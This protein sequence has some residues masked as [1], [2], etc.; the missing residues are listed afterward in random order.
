[1]FQSVHWKNMDRGTESVDEA[2]EN[3]LP[4]I[5]PET[6]NKMREL[7]LDHEGQMPPLTEMTPIISAIITPPKKIT[8][9]QLLQ[10]QR[11][12]T[13]IQTIA[14]VVIIVSFLIVNK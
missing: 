9:N 1:M 13:K 10:K 8:A 4:G 14:F 3:M 2:I 7:I 11:P 6:R 5:P 12:K